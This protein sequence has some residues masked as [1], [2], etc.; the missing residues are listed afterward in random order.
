MVIVF[1]KVADTNITEVKTGDQVGTQFYW[2]YDGSNWMVDETTFTISMG[3]DATKITFNGLSAMTPY[4]DQ[5][6][7]LNSALH[8]PFVDGINDD[9]HY[10]KPNSGEIVP[11]TYEDTDI[12]QDLID[13]N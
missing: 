11:H 1:D 9:P 8:N 13:G 3:A 10:D 2:K 6:K 12:E 7:A 5:F 4:V